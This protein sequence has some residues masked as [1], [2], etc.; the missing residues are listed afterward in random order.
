[1]DDAMRVGVV[2]GPGQ[3]LDQFGAVPRGLGLPRQR[4]LQAAALDVLQG[5]I[6]LALVLAGQEGANVLTAKARIARVT[7]PRPDSAVRRMPD[8]IT[9]IPG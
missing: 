4:L 8:L 7:D 9:T 3:R 1:M 5:Q 6:Q 2:D